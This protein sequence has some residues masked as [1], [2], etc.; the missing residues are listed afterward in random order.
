MVIFQPR[1][2]SD[3]VVGLFERVLPPETIT[4][5]G[6]TLTN[7]GQRHR[8]SRPLVATISHTTAD[9]AVTAVIN[10]PDGVLVAARVR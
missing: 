2:A 7:F 10:S 6:S 8:R 4:Q 1:H 3:A 9:G 5:R